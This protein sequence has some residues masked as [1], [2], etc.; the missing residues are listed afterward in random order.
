MD[1][2]GR[3]AVR[4]PR[5]CI[6]SKRGTKWATNRGQRRQGQRRQGQRRQGQRSKTSCWSSYEQALA[7]GQ[8]SQADARVRAP[9][10]C[11]HSFSHLGDVSLLSGG[12]KVSIYQ[13][14]TGRLAL[15]SG[16]RS[17]QPQT[18][19]FPALFIRFTHWS[20]RPKESRQSLTRRINKQQK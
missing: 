11:K 2:R 18:V 7:R 12:D 13:F 6:G 16:T 5:V 10:N 9:P 8:S 3:P 20:S 14:I 19:L 15:S 1:S 17:L 4:L